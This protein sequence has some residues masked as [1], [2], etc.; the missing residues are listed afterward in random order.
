[1][2]KRVQFT[3]SG[4]AKTNDVHILTFLAKAYRGIPIALIDSVFGFVERTPLYGG[5]IFEG[6]ELT[7]RD[8]ESLYEVGIGVRLPFS[9]R[10]QPFPVFCP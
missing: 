1:M 2:A 9:Y 4:R 5:R 3:V 8:V 7:P 10:Y 6:A